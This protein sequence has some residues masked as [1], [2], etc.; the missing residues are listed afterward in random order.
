MF[1]GFEVFNFRLTTNMSF[2]IFSLRGC[3]YSKR[4]K[5]FTFELFRYGMI[6]CEKIR[7]RRQGMLKI[8]ERMLKTHLA[9]SWYQNSVPVENFFP[10]MYRSVNIYRVVCG[11]G[12]R[13]ATS[14]VE[15]IPY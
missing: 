2:E 12:G 9:N 14:S 10:C 8:D 13:M 4:D 15:I 7:H 1:V 5:K 6:G 3:L 11:S